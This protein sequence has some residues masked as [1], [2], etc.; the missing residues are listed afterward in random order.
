MFSD[1]ITAI[2][3]SAFRNTGLKKV[4]IGKGVKEIGNYAFADCTSL[5]NV[6]FAGNA[7]TTIGDYAFSGD[8]ALTTKELPGS[9][10]TIGAYAFQNCSKLTG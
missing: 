7:L 3:Y 5:E 9:V 1:K 2:G 6:E 8:V 10:T 4:V